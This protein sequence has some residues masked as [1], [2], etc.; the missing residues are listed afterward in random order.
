MRSIV[1]IASCVN[2]NKNVAWCDFRSK[3]CLATFCRKKHMR[4]HARKARAAQS[5]TVTHPAH[6]GSG[7]GEMSN[8]VNAE[9]ISSALIGEDILGETAAALEDH[10]IE[11][12]E[13]VETEDQE[14]KRR[15]IYLISNQT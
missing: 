9:D 13:I 5:S 7:I 2:F 4:M 11:L 3:S 1:V 10:H 6:P 15:A 12:Q 8:V 14:E